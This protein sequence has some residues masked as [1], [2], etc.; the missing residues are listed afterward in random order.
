MEARQFGKFE[1]TGP[2]HGVDEGEFGLSDK[3]N[4]LI[5][6]SKE[7]ASQQSPLK[8]QTKR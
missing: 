2:G 3:Q 1:V 4:G 7:T 6:I 8:R 5:Y